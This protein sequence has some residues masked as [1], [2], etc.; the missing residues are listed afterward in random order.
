MGA[1]DTVD[2]SLPDGTH[3]LV[4][5]GSTAADVLK[6]WRPAEFATFLAASWDGHPIDL[7]APIRSAGSLR[8]LRFSDPEG[9]E[10]LQHSAAHLVAKALTEAIPQALPTAGPPTEEGFY[11]DFD[12]RPLTPEDV[13]KV[14]E[15]V[16]RSVSSLERFERVEV[17]KRE[18]LE[19]VGSNRHKQGYVAE[20]AEGVPVS[21]YRTGSFL[22]LC[23][24]PHVPDT[25]WL[26]GLHVLGVSAITAGGDP[27]G[28]ARQRVRG[29]AFPTRP[30][31]D[32][33]LKLREEAEARDHR[34]VGARLGLFM[35]IDEAPGFPFWLPSGM[36][37]VR[38]LERFVTEHFR[39]DGYQEVRTPL[40]FAQ[41]VY[42]TSGHWEHYR[43]NIFQTEADG[44]VYGVKPMNC[45]GSML[46]FQSTSRS[47][48]ELPLRLAE[49]APLH[50][51]ERSGTLHGLTRVREMVQDDAHLFVSEDQIEAEL[52]KLLAWI[53]R[54]FTTFRL[55]W[56]Y[57]LSTRPAHFLGETA[58]WDRAEATLE[59]VLKTS[60]V[61][62]RTSAGEGAFYGPKIDIHVRDS[63]GR[64]WQTGTIQLDYQIPARFH[65]QYQG[66]DGQLHTPI[67]IHRTILGTWE[68]FL[69][70]LLEHCAGRLPPWL[71]P[72]QVRIIPVAERHEGLGHA[73]VRELDSRGI[74]ADL[75]RSS[76]TLSKRV[77]E[78]E[79][80]KIPWVAVVGDQEAASGATAV[81]T[82][83]R[84][85]Q[86]SLS[87]GEFID[88]VLGKLRERAFEP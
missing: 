83:G 33:Y 13:A 38:E 76:E 43:E 42:E 32:A 88:E 21:F 34:V 70:V 50:R 26:A 29:V 51:L 5:V 35:F 49:F 14:R 36:V 27:A 19:W 28:E 74:R 52:T 2:V 10:V 61:P 57:E 55:A 7:A 47:Y 40:M 80:A 79:V 31:L 81:R 39:E 67:V 85:G 18:A 45:P 8:P 20:V 11:Y 65:L 72:I 60:G 30:E 56:S 54:A 84:K 1:G 3:Q 12:V 37:V 58:Q 73:F 41:S 22:D 66:A 4:A 63:L 25:G 46:I 75:A 16:Q 69:G 78:A 59:K 9:R 23:R 48:R 68:R 6:Q 82:H 64:P 62:Y 17:S 24:G 77:R 53:Q 71:A 44:R 87:K 86:R 15:L